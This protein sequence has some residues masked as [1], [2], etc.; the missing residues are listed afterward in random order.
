MKYSPRFLH[1]VWKNKSNREKVFVMASGGIDSGLTGHVL[2]TV[3]YN[4]TYL[5]FEYGHRGGEVEKYAITQLSKELGIPLVVID[6]KSIY[7]ACGNVSMLTN[8]NISI[9]TGGNDI[10]STIAWVPGRNMLFSVIASVLAESLVLGNNYGKVWLASGF[11]QLSEETGGYPDNSSRFI[12][13]LVELFKYG[14]IVGN[15]I[16]F[17]P[18]LR[19]LT[20]TEQWFLGGVLN[21]PFKHTCSCDDPV[22]IDGV[23]HLCNGCGSTKL[24]KWAAIRAGVN[25]PRSFYGEDTGFVPE[26]LEV[27]HMDI[28]NIVGRIE[29][30]KD[31][32]NVLL[33]R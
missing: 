9:T 13:S 1:P 6:I 28:K 23:I 2:K 4:V 24:S 16:G 5:H 32:R 27:Q 20:K 19:N 31:K 29:I 17:I 30:P 22:I 21:F 18:V 15:R 3:G 7:E 14:C 8:E 26:D 25:D 12:N 10:K 11:A 33:R